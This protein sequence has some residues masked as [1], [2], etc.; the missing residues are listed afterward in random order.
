MS[1]SPDEMT[2]G[3]PVR[4]PQVISCLIAFGP[5]SEGVGEGRSGTS[6]KVPGGERGRSTH[7]MINVGM[8]TND[9]CVMDVHGVPEIAASIRLLVGLSGVDELRVKFVDS[10]CSGNRVLL[11]RTTLGFGF[12]TALVEG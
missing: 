11:C 12:V 5:S 8:Q 4:V 2:R 6:E 9:K 1:S 10:S 7:I 3:V